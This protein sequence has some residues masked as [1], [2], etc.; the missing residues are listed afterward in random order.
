MV[1]AKL[2]ST[3][4]VATDIIVN[5]LGMGEGVAAGYWVGKGRYPNGYWADFTATPAGLKLFKLSTPGDTIQWRPDGP[6][7]K[8]FAITITTLAANHPK[9]RD[10]T[11][12]QDTGDSKTADFTQVVNLDGVPDKLQ[13]IAHNP[14]NKLTSLH[15]ATFSLANGAWQLA[16]IQ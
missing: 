3:P 12:L 13:G 5:D 7:D 1:Q 8:N 10:L 6:S 14:P 16:S 2:D 15:H 9:A 11:D 4:A